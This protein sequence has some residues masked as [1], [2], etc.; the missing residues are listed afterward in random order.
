MQ[1]RLSKTA[2]GGTLEV[3][4]TRL[5]K[6]KHRF[7]PPEIIGLLNEGGANGEFDSVKYEEQLQRVKGWEL[8]SGS[9]VAKF[10][11]SKT[12]FAI[13]LRPESGS[14]FNV[15]L[16]NSSEG[17]GDIDPGSYVDTRGCTA[18]MNSL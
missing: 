3:R 9:Y 12:L 17:G 15:H 1:F 14:F 2:S 4:F 6:Y 11:F 7:T 10:N 16:D 18:I 13:F 5:A 8:L